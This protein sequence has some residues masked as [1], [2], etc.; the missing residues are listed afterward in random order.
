MSEKFETEM[1]KAQQLVRDHLGV[2]FKGVEERWRELQKE[3]FPKHDTV[4]IPILVMGVFYREGKD[5]QTGLVGAA[6]AGPEAIPA[7][8]ISGILKEAEEKIDNLHLRT[9]V[10]MPDGTTIEENEV[11]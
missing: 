8:I 4:L 9:V 7:D 10:I 5:D 11:Q 1:S 2:T 3:A 6:V